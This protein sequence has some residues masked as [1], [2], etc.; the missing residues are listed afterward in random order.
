MKY[1]REK[2]A[3]D[4]GIRVVR[5]ECDLPLARAQAIYKAM[6]MDRDIDSGKHTVYDENVS[7]TEYECIY[8]NFIT[9]FDCNEGSFHASAWLYSFDYKH[10]RYVTVSGHDN[11]YAHF[12][13]THY[14]H[15]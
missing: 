5:M 15:G 10:N 12:E 14:Y 11:G 1:I 6:L 4:E 2:Y 8:D 7:W 13:V 9:V 3:T